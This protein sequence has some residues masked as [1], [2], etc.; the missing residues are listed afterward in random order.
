MLAVAG[1]LYAVTVHTPNAEPPPRFRPRRRAG[2]G[3]RGLQYPPPSGPCRL[4]GCLS[5]EQEISVPG[6][7]GNVFCRWLHQNMARPP[8][9]PRQVSAILSPL[10]IVRM[11]RGWESRVLCRAGVPLTCRGCPLSVTVSRPV[12]PMSSLPA[13]RAKRG[14][15]C[16]ATA[17]SSLFHL[18][19][20]H[21]TAA[22]DG[23]MRLPRGSLAPRKTLTALRY[24]YPQD[25]AEICKCWL[26]LH[27]VRHRPTINRAAPL[28][29]CTCSTCTQ[30]QRPSRA[31]TQEGRPP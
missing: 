15:F 9:A 7:L 21:S 10:G 29:R 3:L 28:A 22:C 6:R 23:P 4:T 19:P 24:V 14:G 20:P 26:S 17:T 5:T 11:A 18:L 12:G 30:H 8:G 25:R 16:S 1:L 31:T 2:E 27:L 13:G